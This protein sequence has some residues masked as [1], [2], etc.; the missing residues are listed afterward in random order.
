MQRHFSV[1]VCQIYGW[2]LVVLGLSLTTMVC[3]AQAQERALKKVTIAV[4]SQVLN[5]SYP[6]LMMPLA[7]GYWKQ[8]GYD[9]NVIGVSGSAQALQQLASGGIEFA[10][11]NATN[12]IQANTEGNTKVRGVMGNGVIDWGLAVLDDGPIKGVKDLKSK[13]VGIVSLATGGTSLL[14]GLLRSNGIDPETDIQLIAVGG[15]APAL[16][17]L[18]NNRVQALMFWQSALTGFENSGTKLKVF[19]SPQW[20]SMPDFTLTAMQKLLDSDPKMV[21]AIVRGA[22]KGQLF[23]ATNPD[24]ARRVHW[25]AFAGT[26]P[27]GADEATLVKWDLALLNAQLETLNDA[28]KMNG[29][30]WIGAM[31]PAAYGRFQDFMF[32]EKQITK[33]LP[34]ET[35]IATNASLIENANRFDREEVIA[36]ATTCKG[37]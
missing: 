3:A 16:D 24:C 2:A 34:R 10:E 15:G 33:Q 22:A 6:W 26:K 20:R 14:K 9:V 13:K 35:F 25:K 30:K 4:G 21:E 5:V 12:L 17:A 27:T 31:D 19:R 37:W 23:A 7:L 8:E 1:R 18:K 28:F 36:A 11:L 32:D 29:G